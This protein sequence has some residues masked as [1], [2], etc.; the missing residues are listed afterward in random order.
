MES[1][2]SHMPDNLRLSSLT[3]PGRNSC[4]VASALA[5]YGWPISQCQSQNTPLSVQLNSGI[6]VLDVRL[7]V[8]DSKLIAYHGSYPQKTPYQHVLSDIHSFLTSP[9]SCR[10]TIVIS[11]KQEDYQKT[12]VKV[13]SSL[14]HD[15]IFNGPGGSDM[16]FFE[17]RIPSLGEVRGKVV[18]LSRFGG[19]GNEWENGLEGL[20]IHPTAWPDSEKFGFSWQCKDTLVRTHDWYAIPSF[21]AIPE[22][23]E[24]ATRI[25]VEA[26]PPNNPPF[27]VLSISYTSAA[28]FPL[29]MPPTVAKGFGWPQVGFGVEGVNSRVARWLLD[30]FSRDD[31]DGQLGKASSGEAEKF[32]KTLSTLEPKIRGWVFMDFYQEPVE[33]GIIHL[34]VECNYR[35]RR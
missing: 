2:L 7:A 24:R 23:V 34:L 28:S 30:A 18:L 31:T 29:A 13:F 14:V 33:S 11:I 6:R 22:K 3:L 25:L 5:F 1:F 26:E 8:V 4:F 15:E 17:N 10:E 16:W 21:L 27:P 35:G 20:G 32:S 12:P 19:D 9:L